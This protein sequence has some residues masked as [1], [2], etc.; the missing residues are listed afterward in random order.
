MFK[1]PFARSHA[2][3]LKIHGFHTEVHPANKHTAP[4]WCITFA[5]FVGSLWA[6]SIF[7]KS[8]LL[9]FLV[10]ALSEKCFIICKWVFVVWYLVGFFVFVDKLFFCS[11]KW[12]QT[13]GFSNISYT[14]SIPHFNPS[15]LPGGK[16]RIWPR[17]RKTSRPEVDASSALEKWYPCEII[18]NLFNLSLCVCEP[19]VS[20]TQLTKPTIWARTRE[21]WAVTQGDMTR[22]EKV[23]AKRDYLLRFWPQWIFP[24]SRPVGIVGKQKGDTLF[25]EQSLHI[26]PAEFEISTENLKFLIQNDKNIFFFQNW[27]KELVLFWNFKIIWHPVL[28][29]LKLHVT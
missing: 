9:A 16:T 5:S 13:L 21:T 15:P 23:A 25:E 24:L 11:K 28:T 26:F 4:D 8:T 27:A 10:R 7:Y 17:P 2:S 1:L 6:L 12:E 14:K 29:S 3:S 19:A 18:L 20:V 22:P